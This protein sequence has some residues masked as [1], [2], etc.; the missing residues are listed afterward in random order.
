MLLKG[1]CFCKSSSRNQVSQKPLGL[2]YLSED[3]GC[4]KNRPSTTLGLQFLGLMDV[5]SSCSTCCASLS[6]KTEINPSLASRHIPS[7]LQNA[8]KCPNCTHGYPAAAQKI[9]EELLPSIQMSC[10]RLHEPQEK[11]LS[12]VPRKQIAIPLPLGLCWQWHM[13][14]GIREEF[15][16]T[17]VSW[18]LLGYP[19]VTQVNILWWFTI[20]AIQPRIGSY[21]WCTLNR[22][23]LSSG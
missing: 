23:K 14:R 16:K 5:F 21:G 6:S 12:Q 8:F 1:Y 9:F 15:M 3:M 19:V 11:W 17:L 18:T 4:L 20:P 22:D 7:A 10:V 2:T 13:L